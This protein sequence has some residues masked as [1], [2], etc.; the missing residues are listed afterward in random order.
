MRLKAANGLTDFDP[1]CRVS[2][3]TLGNLIQ[4][5]SKGNRKQNDNSHRNNSSFNNSLPHHLHQLCISSHV[6]FRP[7]LSN[8]QHIKSHCQKNTLSRWPRRSGKAT[9]P[10]PAP[11][12]TPAPVRP[13]LG[14]GAT[15]PGRMPKSE[16]TS[17]ERCFLCL[18]LNVGQTGREN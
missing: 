1:H 4:T 9:K 15:R 8:N 11:L 12:L 16:S 2:R 3:L 17:G 7:R 13:G 18:M 6:T 5:S 10:A 14:T